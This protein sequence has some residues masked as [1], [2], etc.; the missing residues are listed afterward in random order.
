MKYFLDTNICIYFLKGQHPKLLNKMMTMHP[1]DIKIP[2]MVAA[3]LFFGAKK[4]VKFLKNKEMI[5]RFLS[6][7]EIVPFDDISSIFYAKIRSDLEK[8]GGMVGPNDLIIASTV[9]SNQGVLITNNEKE[10]RRIN[11][12]QVENWII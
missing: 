6:P 4:S 2:S 11:E 9:L 12:L 10:F 8:K 1:D 3:E 5:K 7:F